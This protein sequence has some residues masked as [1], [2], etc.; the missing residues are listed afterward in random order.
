MIIEDEEIMYH[1]SSNESDC[2]RTIAKK[3]PQSSSEDSVAQ[4]MPIKR[5][6][7]F[8]AAAGLINKP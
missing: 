8:M 5:R 3:R 4:I 1:S 7:T 2:E 6:A